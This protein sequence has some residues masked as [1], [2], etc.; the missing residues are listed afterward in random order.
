MLLIFIEIFRRI[1]EKVGDESRSPM[2]L[3]AS[4]SESADSRSLAQVPT[5]V[6]EQ[7]W[8]VDIQAVGSGPAAH[9]D[10]GA[11]SVTS[12]VRYS[13]QVNLLKVSFLSSVASQPPVRAFS[14]PDAITSQNGPLSRTD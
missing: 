14:N 11:N 2:T 4:Q 12:L 1:A 6:W 7:K 5:Q 8:V 13:L 9:S 3:D 10:G